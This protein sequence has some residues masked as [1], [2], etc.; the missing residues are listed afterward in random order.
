MVCSFIA[1]EPIFIVVVLH[2]VN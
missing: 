1:N 2:E